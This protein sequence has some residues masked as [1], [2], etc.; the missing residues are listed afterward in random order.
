M[1]EQLTFDRG[2]TTNPAIAPD[3]K[4]I[5]YASDRA[6]E[7]NLDIWVQYSG[8]EPVRITRDPAD[9]DEPSFSPDGT[10]IAFQSNKNGGGIYIVSSLGGEQPRRIAN[11]GIHP[12]FSPDGSTHGLPGPYY[13]RIRNSR[14]HAFISGATAQTTLAP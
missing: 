1:L 4:L 2:L 7:G 9:E 5:A 10:K 14:S 12:Q 13:R 8:G 11:F 6:A 3:G